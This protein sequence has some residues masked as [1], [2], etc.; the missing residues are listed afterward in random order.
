MATTSSS[1]TAGQRLDVYELGPVRG[2]PE[3]GD[4]PDTETARLQ[5][6]IA[7]TRKE[8]GSTIEA[9]KHKLSPSALTEQAS[10]AAREAPIE[11]VEHMIHDAE[12]NLVETGH[13]MMDTVRRN[14]IPAA[15]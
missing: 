8:M 10:S 11:K 13:S 7:R 1:M 6:D 4:G 12:E 3:E 15:L 9:L 2:E 14:P 5:A